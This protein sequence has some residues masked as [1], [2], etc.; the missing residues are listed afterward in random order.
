MPARKINNIYYE[1]GSAARKI[2]PNEDVR[3]RNTKNVARNN[4]SKQNNL[5][6]QQQQLRKKASMVACI[7]CGFTMSVIITYMPSIY[8]KRKDIDVFN[9]LTTT[10]LWL[11]T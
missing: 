7:L 2:L 4:I 3:R 11:I 5:K 6:R 9:I 1:D 10:F 8:V